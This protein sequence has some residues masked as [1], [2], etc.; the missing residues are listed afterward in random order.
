[1]PNFSAAEVFAVVSNLPLTD[2]QVAMVEADVDKHT[3][4]IAGAGSGKTQM[5]MT[6][7]LYLVANEFARPDEILGLTFTRKA[8]SE[9]S[10]RVQQ[11]LIRLR[12]SSKWPAGLEDDFLPA[13]I[14]TYNSF[15]NE[16]FRE[17][18][19]RIGYDPDAAVVTD[20]LAIELVREAMHEE[21]A[22]A[23]SPVQGWSLSTH[24]LVKRALR[25]SSQLSD[26]QVGDELEHELL[27]FQAYLP[28][29]PQNA[30]GGSKLNA[31]T[32]EFIDKAQNLRAVVAVARRYREIK[33]RAGLVDYS[34][35]I[36]LALEASSLEKRELGYRFVLLDEYQ[37]TSV[38][39][40]RLLAGIFGD[41]IVMAVGDP[42]QAIYGWRGASSDSLGGFAQSFGKTNTLSLSKSWRSGERIVQAAN[43]ISSKIDNRGL[44]VTELSSGL[45]MDST[46]S[47]LQLADQISEAR[48]VAAWLAQRVTADSTQA[49]LCR[50]KDTIGL[51]AAELKKQ[52]LRVE[53]TG[54]S[55]LIEQPEVA[56]LISIIKSVA[57]PE[58]GA[59][60][61]RLL[62]GPRFRLS[63]D[64][65]ASIARAARK[66]SKLRSEVTDD[67]PIT[68]VEMIDESLKPSIEKQLEISS[69]TLSR[70]RELAEMLRGLRALNSLSLVEICWAAVRE[71]EL[72]IELFA[73]V[74]TSNPLV[75]LQAFISRVAEY[76]KAVGHSDL[77]SLANWLEV[78]ADLETFELPRQVDRGVVQLMTIHAAK[79][80]EWDFVVVPNLAQNL[81]PNKSKESSGWLSGLSIPNS[82]RLDAKSL[83]QLSWRKAITQQNFKDEVLEKFKQE[84]EQHQVNEE[85]R[86]A[87][88][89]LTRAAKEL[90]VTSS[91][92]KLGRK[93]AAAPSIFFEELTAS[94]LAQPIAPLTS[95]QISEEVIFWPTDPLGSSR[96]DWE[97]AAKQV[98]SAAPGELSESDQL[99]LLLAERERPEFKEPP[100]LPLRLSA[101]AIVK[102]LSDPV[103]FAIELAR[104]TPSPYSASAE[105]GSLFHATLE[106]AFLAGAELDVSSWEVDQKELGEN[107]LG[108]RFAGMAPVAIERPVEFE[109][110]GTVVVCKLD[111]VF[112][113]GGMF[114]VV[115][116]K[117]GSTPSHEQLKARAIQL[118]L[119]R[120]GFAKA[121][122]IPVERIKASFF[123]AK[124]GNEVSPDLPGEK[125]LEELLRGF[126]RA[127]R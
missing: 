69:E 105:S 71:F 9:F 25:L 64:D 10:A 77:G 61:F 40:A 38:I 97:R 100:L 57:D 112:E 23:D 96:A 58:A 108:S 98:E 49:V 88:V 6:R 79:G 34:D 82:L 99:A 31:Y 39:Q 73:H 59:E 13:K 28:S 84:L 33:R 118:A 63:P 83:P 90:L 41:A 4:V 66:L 102:L 17:L 3:L 107:F 80:L 43:V 18:A 74:E 78:A 50:T 68:L 26:H 45:S 47:S 21:F 94:S 55:S 117:S 51:F 20:S 24:E 35:Q 30:K 110:G 62:S 123:F 85:R 27:D 11:G 44:Q 126:R 127:R 115:D 52:G 104:P 121:E 1:M 101:S 91:A 111:A 81:F 92:E 16:I 67:R 116:W 48:E 2:E 42:N 124:D 14:S 119:Y 7:V 12:E 8:A 95:G 86:L 46:V 113:Q 70:V 122:G 32:Q 60:V 37:D 89:A 106:K 114:E 56:D 65:I 72:D 15:G 87:Y 36:S 120:I 103:G 109:L 93:T 5:M 29:L 22:V 54:L 76:E 53:V 75:N 19:L 125:E